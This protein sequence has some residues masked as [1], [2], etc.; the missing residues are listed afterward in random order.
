MADIHPFRALRY[1][2]Q[3]VSAAQVVTQPYDKITPALQDRYYA[4]SPYNLVRIILGRHQADDNPGNNVYSRAAAYFRDWRQQGVLRQD[5]RPSLYV[6]SQR[7]TQPGSSKEGSSTEMERHGFIALGR[8][9][10]YSAGVVFRHEQTLAKPKAD[11]LDL[12]RATRAHFGQLFMLY[13]G[14]GK[15]DA[16]LDSV[17][18]SEVAAPAYVAPDIEV[19][20]EYEVV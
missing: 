7:F 15:V 13:S 11:R 10:D 5:S 9:E 16:L 17:A 18:P 14:A 2:L 6:Y 12:L 19:S 8:I 20:D 3:Q 4:A 1:D